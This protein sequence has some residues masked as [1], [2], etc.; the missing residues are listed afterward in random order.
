MKNLAYFKCG[1]TK[2]GF[3][4]SFAETKTATLIF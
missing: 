4:K 1:L 3:N 2:Y